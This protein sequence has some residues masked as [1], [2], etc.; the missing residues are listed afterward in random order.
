[1]SIYYF[2][3]RY[4]LIPSTKTDAITEVEVK[5]TPTERTFYTITSAETIDISSSSDEDADVAAVAATGTITISNY[6]LLVGAVITISGFELTE[7]VDWTAATSNDAT[8][9]SLEAAID[10]HT[11]LPDVVSTSTTTNVITLT[12]VTTGTF[13]NNISLATSDA[14]NAPVS[15]TALTGGVDATTGIKEITIYGLN[16]SYAEINETISLNGTSTVT[17]A[18]SFYRV[19]SITITDVG[20]AETAVG[21]I[22]LS[23]STSTQL[24]GRIEIGNDAFYTPTYCVPDNKTLYIYEIDHTRLTD[25]ENPS[26]LGYLLKSYLIAGVRTAK[27]A[28]LTYSL[29]IT[30]DSNTTYTLTHTFDTPFIFTEK[31]DLSVYLEQYGVGLLDNTAAKIVV[32]GLLI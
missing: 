20:S 7:G 22:T 31:E 14:V 28:E 27:C 5:L 32:K 29:N 11:N 25:A 6:L 8:A 4:P 12:A 26:F 15:G 16:S 2:N 23:G 30:G 13:G 1:M 19:N 17:T 10:A 24:I 21:T 9:S 18:T 3:N